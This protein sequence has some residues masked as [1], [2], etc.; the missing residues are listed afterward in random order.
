MSRC[1]GV[2]K[3]RPIEVVTSVDVGATCEQK[4]TRIDVA[5]RGG[6][7]ERSFVV[8][9]LYVHVDASFEGVE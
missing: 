7:H 5:I 6:N 1:A 3:R 2:M 9:V 8:F 4:F